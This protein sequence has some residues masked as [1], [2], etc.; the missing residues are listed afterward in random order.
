VRVKLDENVTV[1][2]VRLFAAAGHEAAT[3]TDEELSGA[4]DEELLDV[5]RREGRLLVTFDLGFGDIRAHP[6]GT[7]PGVV[8]VRLAD[9]QPTVVVG[10][11][12]RFLDDHDLDQLVGALAVVTHDRVRIRRP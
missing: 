9:Q 3:V 10:V 7:H 4:P 2:T 1:A 11:L 12:R 5:C 6:P 8:L